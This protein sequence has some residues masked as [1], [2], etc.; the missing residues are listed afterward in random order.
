MV[1]TIVITKHLDNNTKHPKIMLFYD[2]MEG[3]TDEEEKILFVAKSNLFTL[4]TITLTELEILSITI[5]DA[6]ANT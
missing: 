6:E 5:I 4:G 3:V 2:L 1:C